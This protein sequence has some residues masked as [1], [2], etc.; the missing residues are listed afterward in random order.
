[1]DNISNTMRKFL[2]EYPF[3]IEIEGLIRK[4]VGNPIRD[5]SDMSDLPLLETV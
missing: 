4:T 5:S 1:M 2:N 3:L